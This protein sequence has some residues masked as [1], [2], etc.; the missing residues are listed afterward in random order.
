MIY[1]IDQLAWHPTKP[2]ILLT[3]CADRV[4]RLWNVRQR[5]ALQSYSIKADAICVAWAPDGKTFAIGDKEDI[6]TFYEVERGQKVD[7]QFSYEINEF[8]FRESN[9]TTYLFLTTGT[10]AGHGGR[11]EYFQYKFPELQSV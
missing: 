7:R 8:M 1:S 11:L 10:S 3:Y 4:V 6:L 5:K 9:N 2:E